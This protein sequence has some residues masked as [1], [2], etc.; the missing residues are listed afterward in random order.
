MILTSFGLAGRLG[1]ALLMFG[2]RSSGSSSRA[3]LVP[4]TVWA[5]EV[6]VGIA[7]CRS[8][9]L[10]LMSVSYSFMALSLALPGC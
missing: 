1:P 2:F 10:G 3:R 8:S 6:W 9:I 5:A 4:T 7:V